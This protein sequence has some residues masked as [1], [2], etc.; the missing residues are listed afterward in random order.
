MNPLGSALI[1]RFT[2]AWTFFTDPHP[3]MMPECINVLDAYDDT[4]RPYHNI[5]HLTDVLEKLDWARTVLT[6]D[7]TLNHLP[8]DV[9]TRMFMRIELALFYHDVVYDA[10]AKDNEEKSRDLFNE[11]AKSFGMGEEDRVAIARLIDITAKHTTASALDEQ[12][13]CDCDLAIL[14]ADRETFT[15]Y[16]RNI[17]TEY[18]H[19]PAAIWDVRRPGVLK[20]FL[21]QPRLYKTEAF[22]KR[23]DE[24]A[25]NNLRSAI[26]PSPLARLTRLFKR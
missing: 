21:D 7:G 14:G 18:A 24:A 15:R 2:Q 19:V 3:L 22:H 23:Y 26:T 20:H 12:I 17:R 11:H 8:A 25:R 10:K 9:R 16:D 6:N 1:P 13:L 4:A 5:V